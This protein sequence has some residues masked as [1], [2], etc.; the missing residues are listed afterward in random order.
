MTVPTWAI[1]RRG[2]KTST[3]LRCLCPIAM[4]A[5]LIDDYFVDD[6]HDIE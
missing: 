3:L 4:V 2:L 5:C 1:G 6:L